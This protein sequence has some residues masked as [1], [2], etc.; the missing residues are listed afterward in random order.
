MASK[1]E[2]SRTRLPTV[3]ARK[4]NSWRM[5]HSQR[6][7]KRKETLYGGF[8]AS[9]KRNGPSAGAELGPNFRSAGE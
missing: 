6:R 7:T 3:T 4:T 5:V 2:Q 8:F 1:P 9:V